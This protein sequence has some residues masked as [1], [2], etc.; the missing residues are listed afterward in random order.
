MEKLA[1]IWLIFGNYLLLNELDSEDENIFAKIKE[2]L[3][4]YTSYRRK[5]EIKKNLEI[6]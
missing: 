6:K 2:R 4:L 3:V 5:I 1:L